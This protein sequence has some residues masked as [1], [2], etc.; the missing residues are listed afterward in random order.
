MKNA[1]MVFLGAGFGGVMRYGISKLL[2]WDGIQ[3]P[4]ATM[5]INICGCYIL[6]ALTMYFKDNSSNPL[7]MVLLTTGICGGFTTFST[8]SM[9][10][11]SMMQ[12]NQTNTAIFYSIISILGG[13]LAYWIGW[14]NFS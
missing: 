14:K 7:L 3:F 11:I 1:L 12:N 2:P 10:T 13:L 6:G 5:L 4:I 8:F 9:E